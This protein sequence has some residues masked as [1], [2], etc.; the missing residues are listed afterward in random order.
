[1]AI[2]AGDWASAGSLEL[3]LT[4]ESGHSEAGIVL[5]DPDN[6]QGFNGSGLLATV[7]FGDEAG[8]QRSLSDAPGSLAA[9]TKLYYAPDFF[10]YYWY[11]MNPGDYD[12]NGE[13][14]ISDLTPLAIHFG[15]SSPGG[16]DLTRVES[17]VDGDGNGEINIA[18]VSPI[19]ANFGNSVTDYELYFGSQADYPAEPG[20]P[21]GGV[22]VQ[23]W[24]FSE[25]TGNASQQRLLFQK[26]VQIPLPITN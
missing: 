20:D 10:F 2:E 12:Q 6:T 18:D 22:A 5:I 9:R 17:V 26:T 25:A 7:Q 13:V 1:T 11:Y 14:N 19:G 4:P 21:T 23:S 8:Q 16:F 15:K 24:M 3:A